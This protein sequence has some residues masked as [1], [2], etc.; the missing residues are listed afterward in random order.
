MLIRIA[1]IN[2]FNIV[3][4]MGEVDDTLFPALQEN[5]PPGSLFDVTAYP[6]LTYGWRYD[7]VTE[8]FAPNW[9]QEQIDAIDVLATSGREARSKMV[10]LGVEHDT[11]ENALSRL[12]A[13]IRAREERG[14][15]STDT[16]WW[17]L[18]DESF[19]DQSLADDKALL[20]TMYEHVQACENVHRAAREAVIAA[21]VSQDLAALA[22]AKAPT[23]PT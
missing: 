19:V 18:K 16:E 8:T 7:P 23:W 9:P 12:T 4:G 14:D 6:L 5:Y 11:T 3:S 13:R 10:V 21:C 15:L 1:L 20:V 22:I 17:R 2:T